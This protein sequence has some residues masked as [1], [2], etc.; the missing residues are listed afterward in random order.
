MPLLSTIQNSVSYPDKDTFC[1]N[2]KVSFRISD[3]WESVRPRKLK[4]TWYRIIW[5][6]GHLPRASFLYWL[7]VLNRL[8]TKDI[9]SQWRQLPHLLCD[10]CGMED[11]TRDHFFS[12]LV[13]DQIWYALLT[14]LGFSCNVRDWTYEFDWILHHRKGR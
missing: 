2:S 1:W 12:C 5:F 9:L 14:L 6:R 4:V 8:V 13:T 3:I 7:A 10:F 11:E